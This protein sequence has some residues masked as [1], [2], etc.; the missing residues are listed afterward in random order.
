MFKKFTTFKFDWIVIF[1]PA[2]SNMGIIS[3][4]ILEDINN[5]VRV[6]SNVQQWKNS[7]S[8]IDWF[9][10]LKDKHLLAFLT[11]DIVDFYPS[12]TELHT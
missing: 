1:N 9:T 8:V 12:I 11:F 4:Q 3:K 10:S 5:K 6:H 2:K 7:Q